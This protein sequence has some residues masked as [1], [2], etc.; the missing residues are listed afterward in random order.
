MISET[1]EKNPGFLTYKPPKI[2]DNLITGFVKTTKVSFSIAILAFYGTGYLPYFSFVPS[3]S[4]FVSS[5][6]HVGICLYN[7]NFS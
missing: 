4:I 5:I 6:Y 2:K 1:T 7:C 3:T